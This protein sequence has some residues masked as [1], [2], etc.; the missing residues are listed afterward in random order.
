[1]SIY[2]CICEV[3]FEHV[4]IYA[5]FVHVVVCV[6]VHVCVH[7]RVYVYVCQCVYMCMRECVSVCARCWASGKSACFSLCLCSQVATYNVFKCIQ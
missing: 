5:H 1:M 4:C 6:Y 2:I 7:V 3:M